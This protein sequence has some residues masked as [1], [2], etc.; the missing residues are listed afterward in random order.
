MGNSGVAAEVEVE[1]GLVEVLSRCQ[2]RRD[3]I[4]N[5]IDEQRYEKV[6]S[7]QELLKMEE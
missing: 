7:E 3:W 6:R 1:A 2:L 5:R 4:S